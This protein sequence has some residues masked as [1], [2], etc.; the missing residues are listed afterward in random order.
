MKRV[1][2]IIISVLFILSCFTF[3]SG[4]EGETQY[5]VPVYVTSGKCGDHLTFE[6]DESTGVLT[7]SGY[8]EMKLETRQPDEFRTEIIS[9]NPKLVKKMILP[10]GLT[11]L[12]TLIGHYNLEELNIPESVESINCGYMLKDNKNKMTIRIPKN[13]KTIGIDTFAYAS[14]VIK[15]EI[16]EENPYLATDGYSIF[17]KDMTKL[18]QIVCP[19]EEYKIPDTVYEYQQNAFKCNTYRSLTL[20]E[21]I[22]SVHNNE[23]FNLNKLERIVMPGVMY[24]DR[25]AFHYCDSL[26]YVDM[27]DKTHTIYDG[28]FS[29]CKSLRSLYIP[30]SVKDLNGWSMSSYHQDSET[31]EYWGVTDLFYPG[32]EEDFSQIKIWAGLPK[33]IK[34]H[35]NW[36][37]RGVYMD[38]W[39]D[40]G[41]VGCVDRGIMTGT[42]AAEFSP[43]LELTRA[44]MVQILARI[45]GADLE[46]YEPGDKFKDV[47]KDAWYAEAVE[48]ALENDITEGISD[49]EFSPDTAVTREQFATFMYALNG[50]D[51][52]V[53]LSVYTDSDQISDWAAAPM[54]WAVR[55]GMIT[56]TTATTLS[57]KSTATRAQTAVIVN[58]YLITHE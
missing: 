53:D 16:D 1:L 9:W 34:V 45:A 47:P 19:P 32:T 58:Q 31:G 50:E 39:Y 43:E 4:A 24:I 17:S 30:Y 54:M 6:L 26:K 37:L 12:T 33:G 57:P 20:S 10:D 3:V 51:S 40:A 15:L 42:S 18:I 22:I 21:K 11:S 52:I 38:K 2:S 44:Q 49:D 23:F 8:G 14:N 46:S 36:T 7:I 28:A 56:G 27:G 48:W 13:V 5:E 25:I 35:Y 41:I 55:F 29:M